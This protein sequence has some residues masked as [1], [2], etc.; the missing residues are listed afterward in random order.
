MAVAL[1]AVQR[2]VG[3]VLLQEDRPSA[4]PHAGTAF[5]LLDM[6]LV[7]TVT[8]STTTAAAIIAVWSLVPAALVM[9]VVSVSVRHAEMAFWR[10]QKHAMMEVHLAAA[11]QHAHLKPAGR[12]C[13]VLVVVAQNVPLDLRRRSDRPFPA[14][15]EA[16]LRGDGLLQQTTVSPSFLTVGSLP[17]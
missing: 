8:G 13:P 2:K 10:G 12:V 6:R 7:T 5:G 14:F 1:R 3:I 4:L 17:Q 9:L 11:I 15:R 16:M